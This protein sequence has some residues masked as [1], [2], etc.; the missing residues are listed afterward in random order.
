MSCRMTGHEMHAVDQVA[1]LVDI[2]SDRR[3]RD[4]QREVY[5]LEEH[6]DGE[7]WYPVSC[8]HTRYEVECIHA[9]WPDT[10]AN[11]KRIVTYV[12]TD[13]RA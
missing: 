2:V 5:V 1:G 12:P 6:S 10:K 4:M 11:P 3:D 9:R 8:A 13:T 7:G